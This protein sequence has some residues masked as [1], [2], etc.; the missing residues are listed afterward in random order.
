MARED[1]HFRLR[2]PETLLKQIQEAA[3]ASRRSA[4]AEIVERLEQSLALAN[5]IENYKHAEERLLEQVKTERELRKQVTLL[6]DQI[7]LLKAQ[8]EQGHPIV[9]DSNERVGLASQII[10]TFEKIFGSKQDMGA[11]LASLENAQQKLEQIKAGH[12]PEDAST[13]KPKPKP[14][15][16]RE[17]TSQVANDDPVI[18]TQGGIPQNPFAAPSEPS[19]APRPKSSRNVRL[20]DE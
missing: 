10:S 4:T 18:T 14:K 6:E 8:A 17:Q 15:S 5:L 16:K 20:A 9:Q 19:D 3:S 13:V 12:D 2:I 11:V 1:P 7:A